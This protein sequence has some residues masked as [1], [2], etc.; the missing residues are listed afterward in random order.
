[1]NRIVSTTLLGTATVVVLVAG[2]CAP[3]FADGTSTPA[4]ST[5]KTLAAIQANAKVKTSARIGALNTAIAKVTAAKDISSSD[6]AII[7]GTLNHDLA[8]MNSVE[9]KIASDTTVASA[10]SD[11]KTIFTGYRVYAVA[12]PQARLAGAADR[13]TST[14]VPRLTDAQ[15]KLAKALAGPD[16]SKSTPALQAD[17]T[18]MS[19]QIAAATSALD[20]VSARAL[21]VTP[22]DY[23]ANHTVLASVRSAV[24]T[25]IADLKKA[26]SDGKTVLAAIK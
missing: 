9:A 15:S 4:P 5:G 2:A 1:M 21:A 26:S 22:D 19:A 7:L 20:G 10:A 14:S 18:D 12:V 6:R 13:M 23:N 24:K 3:A 25:A 8:G 11:Y 16:A 17:L